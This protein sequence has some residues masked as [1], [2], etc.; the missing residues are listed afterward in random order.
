MGE[1]WIEFSPIGKELITF[2]VCARATAPT[3]SSGNRRKA[4]GLWPRRGIYWSKGGLLHRRP[5]F[6]DADLS[7]SAW[8]QKGGSRASLAQSP[9]FMLLL[10]VGGDGRGVVVRPLQVA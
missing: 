1:E 7:I 3:E 5:S 8:S 6:F 4:A 2:G 9:P 10:P